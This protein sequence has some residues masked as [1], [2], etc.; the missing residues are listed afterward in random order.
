MSSLS[1][2]LNSQ[3]D[4]ENLQMHC[5]NIGNL[6]VRYCKIFTKEIGKKQAT[7]E[8]KAGEMSVEYG[9]EAEEFALQFGSQEV[10]NF[11]AGVLEGETI[12]PMT[13]IEK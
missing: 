2:S 12:Y 6:Q 1:I 10:W 11:V 8:W 9:K 3:S 13:N 5:Q 4:F 7:S